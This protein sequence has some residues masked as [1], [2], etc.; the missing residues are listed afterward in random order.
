MKGIRLYT[1]RDRGGG[2][3][4]AGAGGRRP[5]CVRKQ[6][7]R[8]QGCVDI[9]DICFSK[10]WHFERVRSRYMWGKWNGRGV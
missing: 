3:G 1:T 5:G 9:L 6:A 7:V 4:G 8:C 2:R 10:I